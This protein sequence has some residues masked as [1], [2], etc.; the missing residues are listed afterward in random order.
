[1]YSGTCI[2]EIIRVQSE[3]CWNLRTES[4]ITSTQF[5]VLQSTLDTSPMIGDHTCLSVSSC[6]LLWAGP[7]MFP[8]VAKLPGTRAV[9]GNRCMNLCACYNCSETLYWLCN[10]YNRTVLV[11]LDFGS[12]HCSLSCQ[13]GYLPIPTIWNF[14]YTVK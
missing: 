13:I 9:G 2:N 1:M 7:A 8:V 10:V 11:M 4:G 12:L 6:G 14:M 3:F 5:G